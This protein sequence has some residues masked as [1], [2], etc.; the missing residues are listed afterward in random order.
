V[1]DGTFDLVIRYLSNIRNTWKYIGVSAQLRA[2]NYV[3]KGPAATANRYIPHALGIP[4]LRSYALGRIEEVDGDVFAVLIRNRQDPAFVPRAISLL[5]SSG[6]FRTA[7]ARLEQLLIPLAPLFTEADI[8]KIAHAFRSNDQILYASGTAAGLL[9]ILEAS[10]ELELA[11]TA[12]K[13]IYDVTVTHEYYSESRGADLN[14]ALETRFG[15]TP[16]K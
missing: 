3:Q 5:A 15:F 7:E 9:S 1:V 8:K 11:K 14:K 13:E 2:I 10:R 16:P 6:G 4:E 12:W